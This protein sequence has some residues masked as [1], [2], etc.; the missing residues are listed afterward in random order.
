MNALRQNKVE[1]VPDMN[2][3]SF[4]CVIS[5]EICL[6]FTTISASSVTSSS[7]T[8]IGSRYRSYYHSGTGLITF[9]I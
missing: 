7:I 4:F 3:F 1:F 9:H 6:I 5:V 8:T 2:H